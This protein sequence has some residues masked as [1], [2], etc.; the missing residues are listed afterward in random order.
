[1]SPIV[2]VDGMDIDYSTINQ[3]SSTP[4]K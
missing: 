1:V 2:Q 4:T 3:I